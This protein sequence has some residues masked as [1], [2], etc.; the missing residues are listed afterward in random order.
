M[1]E[2]VSQAAFGKPLITNI[3]R[4]HVAEAII[5]LALEPE[6]TW[7]SADYAGWD[8]E[9]SDGLRLEVKQSAA[10]QSW[11]TDKPN[12]PSFDVAARTGYWEGGT[13]WIEKP[14]RAAHLYVLAHHGIYDDS[15]D[16]RDPSQWE[17]FVIPSGS[18]PDIKRIS[19]KTVQ[20]LAPAVNIAE[21]A[22]V[23]GNIAGGITLPAIE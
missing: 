16:H 8:F 12:K 18:L 14:G 22:K 23:V 20:G 2:K 9:R 7:C 3:L 11:G 13:R 5:A 17:F 19:L 1:V 6:W 4:G 15:A 21:L 10:R